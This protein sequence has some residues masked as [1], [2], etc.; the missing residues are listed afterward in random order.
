MDQQGCELCGRGPAEEVTLRRQVGMLILM[1]KYK[2][3][4]RLCRDHA[5]EHG[6]EWLKKTLVLGWWG[7]FSFFVNFYVIATD[8]AALRKAKKMPPP[9]PPT[10]VMATT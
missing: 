1:K 10:P 6:R 2:Y 8:L 9:Q 4:G 5:L 3:K 7:F